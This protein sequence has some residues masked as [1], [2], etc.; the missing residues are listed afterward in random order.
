LYRGE[1]SI[2]QKNFHA[3]KTCPINFSYEITPGK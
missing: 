2:I 3:S 1:N